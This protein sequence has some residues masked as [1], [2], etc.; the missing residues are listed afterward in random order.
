MTFRDTNLHDI[1]I[2]CVCTCI[3][4]KSS[5]SCLAR[6]PYA[7]R[8]IPLTHRAL[9]SAYGLVGQP[10]RPSVYERESRGWGCACVVFL[11]GMA[12]SRETRYSRCFAHSVG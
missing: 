11:V 12:T 1:D 4:G 6:R 7:G 9:E 2:M 3:V 8:V 5:R 10:S